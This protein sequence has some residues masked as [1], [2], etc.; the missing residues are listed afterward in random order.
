MAP[1]PIEAIRATH[2]DACYWVFHWGGL[3]DS[4]WAEKP[5]LAHIVNL[6]RGPDTACGLPRFERP[7]AEFLLP[8]IRMSEIDSRSKVPGGAWGPSL[9]RL[10]G[11]QPGPGEPP[12][13]PCPKCLE[14]LDVNLQ[15]LTS[16]VG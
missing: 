5:P 12:I 16:P 15:G 10:G 4:V 7:P 11:L 3:F 14:A 9:D 6:G 13:G 2:P 1:D 8:H